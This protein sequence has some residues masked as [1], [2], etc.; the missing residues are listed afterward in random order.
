[1]DFNGI[2]EIVNLLD[3]SSIS[4]FEY[5]T[6]DG[7]IKIDKSLSRAQQSGKVVSNEPVVSS[8]T[9]VIANAPS[10]VKQIVQEKSQSPATEA[11][12][13]N[14]KIV[15][16]PMVGT[17]YEAPSSEKPAFVKMSDDVNKGDT[18]CIIEAMKLMNE[19]ESDFTGT[20]AEILVK[21]GDMVEYGQ[22]LFKIKEN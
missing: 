5:S 8:D 2:K 3:N 13:E 6:N 4:Y 19:I 21:N 10:A 17:F 7:H 22:P 16:A 12:D 11:Q 18:L 1:M 15:T 14:L 9:E 20:I